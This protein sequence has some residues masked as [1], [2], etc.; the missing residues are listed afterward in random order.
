MGRVLSACLSRRPERASNGGLD[1][2]LAH[3][4][5]RGRRDRGARN[6]VLPTRRLDPHAHRAPRVRSRA[7]ARACDRAAAF[8]QCCTIGDD[9]RSVCVDGFD[10]VP[11]DG[12]NDASCARGL[13]SR[14]RRRDVRGLR[15]DSLRPRA[16]LSEHDAR[17]RGRLR[18]LPKGQMTMLGHGLW[19]FSCG[20]ALAA[21]ATLSACRE[22][23]VAGQCGPA[24]TCLTGVECS[25][26]NVR[27]CQE[28][29]CR[30]ALPPPQN[31]PPLPPIRP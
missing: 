18:H 29:H 26:D 16:L 24:P 19:T 12:P 14:Q 30:P 9:P 22:P 7:A 31:A 2:R 15:R 17:R 1:G 10:P 27:S 4:G 28:C 6:H 20:V 21:L 5:R 13:A 8:V 25:Y 11:L 23:N 3:P